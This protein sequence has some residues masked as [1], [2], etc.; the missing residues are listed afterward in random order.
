MHVDDRKAL[1]AALYDALAIGDSARLGE[2]LHS[3]FEGQTAE[4]MPFD[5]GGTYRGVE[6]MRDRFWWQIGRHYRVR[7][8]PQTFAATDEG[9][10]VVSG[11]YS[12]SARTTGRTLTASFVHT[13]GFQDNRIQQLT[14]ETDTVRWHEALAEKYVTCTL[15][16]G[17]A[18]LTLDRGHASNA[19]DEQLVGDLLEAVRN[20]SVLDGM[21]ALLIR[22]NGPAFTPGGDIKLFASSD[23]IPDTILPMTEAY[24]VAL[25]ALSELAVPVVAAVHGAVAGG[26]LGLALVADVVF[27]AEGTKFAT[28]F[29]K[30]GLSGDGGCAHFLPRLVGTR[31]AFELYYDSRVLDAAEALDWGLIS[32]VVPADSLRSDAEAYARRLANGPTVALAE[33]RAH[34]RRAS[35]ATLAEQL[36]AEIDAL[37]RATRSQDAREAIGAFTRKA[38]PVFRGR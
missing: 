12:G 28:G 19:I 5:L 26:G 34:I 9:G 10:L 33:I 38:V 20:L 37:G 3:D 11:V 2:L 27:A 17:L 31:R 29:A 13:F 35:T 1:V 4:G 30:I 32:K 21:R 15:S 8:V 14:Q 7:A 18:I 25:L 24:H 16:D 6:A 22:A 36:E 23:S